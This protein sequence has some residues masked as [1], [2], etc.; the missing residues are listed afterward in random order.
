MHQKNLAI[1]ELRGIAIALVLLQHLSLPNDLLAALGAPFTNPGY[2]GVELFFVISGYVVMHSLQRGGWDLRRYAVRRVFRLYPA[3][4]VFLAVSALVLALA[5]LHQ[6]GHVARV[7]FGGSLEAFLTQGFG[8]LAGTLINLPG[9]RLYVNG[10]MWS[11]SVELQFY[12]VLA[13]LVGLLR[14]LRALP[15]LPGLAAALFAGAMA[16]RLMGLAG[17]RPAG[18]DYLLNYKF[19]FILAGVLMA[20][21]P[22]M[23]EPRR[24]AA[25]AWSGLLVALVILALHRSPL[26]PPGPRDALEGLAMPLVCLIFVGVVALA[27]GMQGSLLPPLRRPLLWLGDRSYA[28]YLLHFPCLAL[29]W[30]VLFHLDPRLTASP[31]LYGP[32]QA[33]LGLGLTLLAS[34]LTFRHVEQPGIRLGD[35]LLSRRSPGP[36]RGGAGETGAFVLP[37]APQPVP[38]LDQHRPEHARAD[39]GLDR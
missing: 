8:V 34:A 21:L 10:A 24:A 15:L 38:A 14:L 37:A 6:P 36:G 25:L 12:V 39:R 27:A 3:L 17:M 19:D 28:I 13:A 23:P 33:G 26:Q 29:T 9:G 4:L 22:R 1:Q 2:S 11:L 35:V 20:L 32:L 31:L 16:A 7:I 18:L 5:A 30:F